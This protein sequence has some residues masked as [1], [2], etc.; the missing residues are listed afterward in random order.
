MMYDVTMLGELSTATAAADGVSQSIHQ[1]VNL[2][3]N[4]ST[5]SSIGQPIHQK[6]IL[7]IKRST[8]SSKAVFP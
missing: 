2:F 1:K 7:F 5:Y 4:R 6:V 3:I 8:Y